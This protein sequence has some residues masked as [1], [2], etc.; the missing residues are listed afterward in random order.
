MPG[1]PD[2]TGSSE[3]LEIGRVTRAH[4]LQGEVVV[5]LVTNRPGRLAAGARLIARRGTAP[6]QPGR[7]GASAQLTIR[8]S[9]PFQRRHLVSF[10]GISTREAAEALQ[11][12]ILLAPPEVDPDAFFVHELIGSEVVDRAGVSHGLVAAVE[13]NPASDLLVGEA[14]WL[15]PLRFVVERNGRRLVVDGPEGL[16]E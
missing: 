2:A 14:G 6:A 5:D 7:A 15:V 1:E 3:L 16:F 4:G 12:L 13:A 8:A 10:D 9:R 11:G